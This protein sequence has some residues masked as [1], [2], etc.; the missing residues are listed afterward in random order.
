M[1]GFVQFHLFFCNTHILL[2]IV[3]NGMTVIENWALTEAMDNLNA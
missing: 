3:E 1:F 2:L